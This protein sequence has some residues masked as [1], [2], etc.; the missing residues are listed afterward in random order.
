MCRL[1]A[2]TSMCVAMQPSA[3]ATQTHLVRVREAVAV[4]LW[5][6]VMAACL[7]VGSVLIYLEYT[8]S[9][10]LELTCMEIKISSGGE[11]QPP[12][13]LQVTL[14]ALSHYQVMR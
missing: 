4:S 3:T 9:H 6:L 5:P 14:P 13:A 10:T 8:H 12:L 1:N 2:S 7:A 11:E